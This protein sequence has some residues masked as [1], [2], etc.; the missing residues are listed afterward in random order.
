MRHSSLQKLVDRGRKAGLQTRELYS[1]IASRRP[2]AVDVTEA[3]S[4]GN[5]Y[6]ASVARDGHIVYLPSTGPRR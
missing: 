5:G 2:E 1:A 4:D 6:V 3:G